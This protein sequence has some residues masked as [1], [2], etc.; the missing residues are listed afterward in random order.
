MPGNEYVLP[1][2]ADAS[3]FAA[4]LKQMKKD[5]GDLK[6]VSVQSTNAMTEGFNKAAGAQQTI[7]SNTVAANKAIKDQG[8]A[9]QQLASVYGTLATAA[10]KATNSAPIKKY[11]DEFKKLAD[12]A[13]KA[14]KLNVQFDD[15][16]MVLFEGVLNR[17]QGELK[18]LTAL[19]EVLKPKLAGLDPNSDEFL[20]LSEQ[21]SVAEKVIAEFNG[22]IDNTA[23][24]SKSLKAQLKDLKA[25]LSLLDDQGLS[26]TKR[27]EQMA[28]KAGQLEDQIGD[29]SNRVKVLASDTKYIDATIQAVTAVTAGFGLAQGA[30]ALFGSENK[31]LAEVLNKVQGAMVI[32]QSL[33]QIQNI[34]QKESALNV[35]TS[36]TAHVANTVAIE[37]ETG[38]VVGETVATEVA[39][40]ATKSLWTTLIANPIGI[41][42]AAIGVLIAAFS[43]Y[44]TKATEAAEAQDE[45]NKSALR[46]ADIGLQGNLSALERNKSLA[47]A[48][49]KNKGASEK[50][51]FNIEQDFQKRKIGLRESYLDEIKGKG[52]DE[53]GV[54][55]TIKDDKAKLLADQ[56]SFEADQRKT[57]NEN[58]KASYQ[59]RLAIEASYQ[60]ALADI[61]KQYRD[62]SNEL[63]I[64]ER[65]QEKATLKAKFDDEVSAIDELLAEQKKAGKLTKELQTVADKEKTALRN[66]YNTDALKLDVDFYKAQADLLIQANN[67]IAEVSNTA[68]GN[69]VAGVREK[70]NS[71]I[72]EIEL[73]NTRITSQQTALTEADKQ[74]IIDN[75]NAIQEL[76][77]AQATAI[78]KI[79]TQAKLDRINNQKDLAISTIDQLKVEGLTE[80]QLTRLKEEKKLEI[81]KDFAQQSIDTITK[82]LIKQKKVTEEQVAQL[83]N[84]DNIQG[85]ANAGVDIFTFLGISIDDAD[86]KAKLTEL[87]GVIAKEL[88]TVPV[89]AFNLQEEF[90]K[91]IGLGIS[92]AEAKKNVQIAMKSIGDAFA[93]VTTIIANNAQA[94]V[95]SIQR[96]IDALDNQISTQQDTVDKQKELSDKGLA[97]DLSNQ[98][99]L[100]DDLKTKKDEEVSAREKAQ[101]KLNEIRKQEA[102][103]QSASIVAGNIE[104]GVNMVN[105]MSKIFKA[106]AGI[107]FV[108]IALAVGFG[109]LMLSTFLAIKNSIK[110]ASSEAPKFREGGGMKLKGN[111]HEDG[112]IGLYNGDKKIA[113]YEG[114]EYL[115]AIRNASTNKY[116]PL[117]DAIN[118]D[119]PMSMR[120]QMMRLLKGT[121]VGLP[122][123]AVKTTIQLQRETDGIKLKYAFGSAN[124]EELGS[125]DRNVLELVTLQKAPKKEVID[126]GDHIIEREPGRS[127]KII[128]S[129]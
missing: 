128:K 73:N 59:Q 44:K 19:I 35:L 84:A 114:D 74:A 15:A 16:D 33:Q 119:N 72:K 95:D 101:E 3:S 32:L 97:N 24:K 118:K 30:T 23:G 88:P 46:F 120:K 49:A 51:L 78:S 52:A 104:T 13:S 127:R 103:I 17:T 21:V 31:E 20:L 7:I 102:I 100:L 2:G 28:I 12:L 91:L 98:Q 11:A 86:V 26:N 106:H 125:I 22:E 85:A 36:R 69:E 126:M 45:L 27:F 110:A 1:I 57:S 53:V 10:G 58:A 68:V 63:I 60:K 64:N 117:L 93:Q 124:N 56:L 66:K 111:K 90:F 29:T 50:E 25:E 83:T 67:A 87:M 14:T 55:T 34:L 43:S 82:N 18:G 71:L 38:A 48:E 54:E 79:L 61:K 116:L 39:N 113:E 65:E 123:E 41:V 109:A 96:V 76:Y 105:A 92:D 70:Y 75:N 129:K 99:R 8:Q 107:P 37:A 122:D 40:V 47:L 6:G 112:G 77:S 5:I 115:F 62:T 9:S 4:E 108:G 121:G 42:L 81:Q 80:E 89:K 94:Q